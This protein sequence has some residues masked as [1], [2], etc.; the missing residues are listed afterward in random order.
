M[1]KTSIVWY[2]DNSEDDNNDDDDDYM[3]GQSQGTVIMLIYARLCDDIEYG[4]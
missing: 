2:G 4:H 3:T 1:V